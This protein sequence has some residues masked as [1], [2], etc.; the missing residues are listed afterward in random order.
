MHKGWNLHSVKQHVK[1]KVEM[2]K[3]I[4]VIT[5][6]SKPKRSTVNNCW[7]QE[8]HSIWFEVWGSSD[9]KDV[10]CLISRQRTKEDMITR[11]WSATVTTH[12]DTMTRHWYVLS[13]KF[14]TT[15]NPS[16]YVEEY[17][18]SLYLSFCWCMDWGS[19]QRMNQR[20]GQDLKGF[21]I[22]K[23]TDNDF[24]STWEDI[25]CNWLHRSSSLLIKLVLDNLVDE[26]RII[27]LWHHDSR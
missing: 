14:I 8:M 22:S 21:V 20:R 11:C 4:S 10:V 2:Q 18:D 1:V 5:F 25:L 13:V 27:I 19:L 6:L 9:W 24:I 26:G 16:F 17:L 12:P 15:L 7:K 3:R 23:W